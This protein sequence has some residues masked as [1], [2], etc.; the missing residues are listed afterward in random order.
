MEFRSA[1]AIN[2]FQKNMKW[3]FLWIELSVELK[4]TL[5]NVNFSGFDTAQQLDNMS[6]QEKIDEEVMA[7][8]ILLLQILEHL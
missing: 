8:H 4:S 5:T 3:D 7:L 1:K 2:R 6:F